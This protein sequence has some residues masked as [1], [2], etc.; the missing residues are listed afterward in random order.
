MLR[1][2]APVALMLVLALLL[3]P[4]MV[5]SH[6]GAKTTQRENCRGTE[7]DAYEVWKNVKNI[8]QAKLFVRR[9]FE[10]LGSID[11][12]I[13][14]LRCQGFNVVQMRGFGDLGPG[15]QK[16]DAIFNTASHGGRRLLTYGWIDIIRPSP[17]A[18]GIGVFLDAE[19]AIFHIS[20]SETIK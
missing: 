2:F 4:K 15:E 7:L 14:W 11:A 18:Q 17:Y 10:A 13:D 1:F 8:E 16:I 3:E 20:I 12:F 9:Q 5:T 19:G 6:A